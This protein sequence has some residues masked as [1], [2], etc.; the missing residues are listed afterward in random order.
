[1]PPRVR[2]RNDSV[3]L[4]GILRHLTMRKIVWG[5]LINPPPPPTPRE[6]KRRKEKRINKKGACA[7]T[8]DK[9][10]LSIDIGAGP[11][12]A[13]RTKV[14]LGRTKYSGDLFTRT[15]IEWKGRTTKKKKKSFDLTELGVVGAIQNVKTIIYYHPGR[16]HTFHPH[17]AFGTY[18]PSVAF[19][20]FTFFPFEIFGRIIEA[21]RF[22]V[23]IGRVFYPQCRLIW[24]LVEFLSVPKLR[25]STYQAATNLR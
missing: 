9:W 10:I 24:P 19:G 14:S 21:Y 3:S 16:S 7:L 12:S 11:N 1:M 22:I 6:R 4:E 8:E 17:S 15:N 2:K 5:H 23:P 20:G 18:L 13:K 25:S